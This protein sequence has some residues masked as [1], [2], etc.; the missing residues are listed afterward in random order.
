[1]NVIYLFDIIIGVRIEGDMSCILIV[2]VFYLSP[3]PPGRL[4]K[5]KFKK[6]RKFVS[7]LQL[8]LQRYFVIPVFLIICKKKKHV[9][10]PFDGKRENC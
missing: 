6:T 2:H 10:I 3:P 5:R 9:L 7:S 8:E 4:E 1:M